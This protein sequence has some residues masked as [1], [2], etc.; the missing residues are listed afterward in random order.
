MPLGSIIGKKETLHPVLSR[1]TL[2]FLADKARLVILGK[3]RQGNAWQGVILW[4]DNY[5]L[6]H[7]THGFTFL[8][9]DHRNF[10]QVLN[11]LVLF[12]LRIRNNHRQE[13]ATILR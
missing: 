7:W 11:W 6:R 10:L 13:E 2:P 12:K 5:N 1:S 4:L 8:L 3:A 9:K